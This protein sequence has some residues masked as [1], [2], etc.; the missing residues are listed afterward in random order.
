MGFIYSDLMV[1]PLVAVNAKYHGWRVALF[2]AGIMYVAV[3]AT[4]LILHTLFAALGITPES[5]RVVSEVAQFR[6][7]YT[8]WM[9]LG[10]VGLA[11]WLYR[12]HRRHMSEDREGGMEHGGG[13]TVKRVVVYLF[14]AILAGGLIARLFV[15]G[16]TACAMST[17][18][19]PISRTA[20]CNYGHY[21]H[22]LLPQSGMDLR[23]F[24]QRF[25]RDAQFLVQLP[26]H[27]ERQ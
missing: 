27:F 20:R 22:S 13:L 21:P 11:G 19:N 23:R 1:P 5:R 2:I 25:S 10:F 12:L 26:D 18:L 15:G 9:N 8:F 16:T 3:V 7:D 14:M 24:N 4:A 17:P 6:I